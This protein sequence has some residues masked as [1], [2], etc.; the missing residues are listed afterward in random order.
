MRVS[1]CW[2]AAA[3]SH[4]AVLKKPSQ[5]RVRHCPVAEWRT[6]VAAEA[7]A[8]RARARE[9]RRMVLGWAGEVR[10]GRGWAL[11]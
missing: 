6:T 2:L 9:R 10:P 5:S 11:R 8:R 4:A 1:K 3:V 7:E